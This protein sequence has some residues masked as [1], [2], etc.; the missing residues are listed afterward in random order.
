MFKLLGKSAASDDPVFPFNFRPI[1][2]TPANSKLFSG[3]LRDRRLLHMTSN[4][5]IDTDI[6]KAFLPTV[7]GVTEHQAKLAAIINRARKSK[8]LS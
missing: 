5:Y 3:I 2:L 6:Q 1:A 8:P 4:G 7:P